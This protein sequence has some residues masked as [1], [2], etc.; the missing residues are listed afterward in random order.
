MIETFDHIRNG[1]QAKLLLFVLEKK[2]R[3]GLS[4]LDR[5]I[6][7]LLRLTLPLKPHRYG[8]RLCRSTRFCASNLG[9][10]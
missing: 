9:G 1:L 5:N 2:N 3:F 6:F 7:A 10:L 8:I 4:M